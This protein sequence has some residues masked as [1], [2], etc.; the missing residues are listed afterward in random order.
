M[1]DP[2]LKTR[3]R[4][5]STA[6]AAGAGMICLIAALPS[7]AAPAD[8]SALT[9]IV[10]TANK[11]GNQRVLDLPESIQAISGDALQSAGVS[12][13]MDIAGQIPGLAVQDLGPGDRKYVIRGIYSAGASTTGIYY[14]EASIS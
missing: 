8:T 11:L 12:Q 2:T 10:V 13:F 3:Y 1:G 9:E 7:L 5:R 6:C 14:G 4:S